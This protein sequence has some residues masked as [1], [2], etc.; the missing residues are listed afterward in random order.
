L[1]AT[2]LY[3]NTPV[4][5]LWQPL[6][7]P[8]DTVQRKTVVRWDSDGQ[9]RVRGNP[10]L[11][12]TQAYPAA[13]GMAVGRMYA[14]L[15][16]RPDGVPLSQLGMLSCDETDPWDDAALGDVLRDLDAM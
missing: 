16:C 10:H 2:L 1:Q 12:S 5:D 8:D 7:V 13:F 4:A 15:P 6:A 3:S 14:N 11:K 9:S